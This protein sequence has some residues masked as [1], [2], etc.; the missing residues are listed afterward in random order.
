MKPGYRPIRGVP[1]PDMVPNQGT[2]A[3]PPPVFP[4]V[5]S[6]VSVPLRPK[7]CICPPGANATCEAWDCPRKT[8]KPGAA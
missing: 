6:A 4:C 7:G 5:P 1:A 8:P 3:Q 2:S